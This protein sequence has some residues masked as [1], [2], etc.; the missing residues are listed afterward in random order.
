MYSF[1]ELSWK[2]TQ[3]PLAVVTSEPVLE[4]GL[5]GQRVVAVA[6]GGFHSGAL[7]EDGGVHMWGDNAHG[8]CGLSGLTTVPNPT[9]V[10]VVDQLDPTSTVK[11]AELACGDQHT[12]ALTVYHEVWA[13]GSGPQL[14][15]PAGTVPAWR[16]QR[17]E[18]LAGRHVLQVACGAFHSLAL[19]RCPA[20]TMEPRRPPPD[21][22][23]QCNQL[24]FTMTDKEDHVIISDN[25]HCP[26]GVE[27]AV[28]VDEIAVEVR[29]SSEGSPGG[30]GVQGGSPGQQKV[31]SS[32]SEPLLSSHSHG[33]PKPLTTGASTVPASLK[34]PK[35]SLSQDQVTDSGLDPEEPA[36]KEL[37]E[38]E[39][40]ENTNAEQTVV[41]QDPSTMQGEASRTQGG[42]GLVTGAKSSPYPDEQAVKDYLKRLSDHTLSEQAAKSPPLAQ[43]SQVRS[44]HS[45]SYKHTKTTLP[46]FFTKLCIWNITQ[47]T[48]T[49]THKQ[50]INNL[51]TNIITSCNSCY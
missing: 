51:I 7:T 49:R 30:K 9:P 46:R 41:D 32:P 47:H 39:A 31:K 43:R 4:A 15:F 25:H 20:P 14:G 12:L 29:R 33:C 6:A 48:H 23:G 18:R 50:D 13:W 35:A 36:S 2:Q 27:A 11:V 28:G 24:L 1:G 21:K 42:A 19:V 34:V 10:A 44:V 3:A 38:P 37:E 5:S 16:P 17:V 26:L 22:C 40:P 45:T 8:Q